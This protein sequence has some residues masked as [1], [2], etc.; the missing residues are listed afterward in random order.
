MKNQ[1]IVKEVKVNKNVIEF[2]YEI[3]GNWKKY[4]DT[5]KK[6]K[7]EYT[8][9]VSQVPKSICVIPL[10]TDIL[11]I[12]WIFDAEIILDE[13]DKNFYESI[14]EFKKGFINMYPNIRLEGKVTVNQLI[15]NSYENSER[16]GQFF[17]GG[18]D[19][20]STL[21][22]H[23][24][25]KPILINIQGSDI[26]VNDQQTIDY[27]RKD[28]C[29]TAEQFRLDI[30][31]IK[32]T[33]KNVIRHRIIN[34]YIKPK[35]GDNYWHGFQHGI[36]I[37]G[38]A[39]PIAYIYQLKMIYIASSFTKEDYATCASDPTIDNFVKL[40][41]TS[42]FHDG[43]NYNRGDKIRN[44][45]QFCNRENEKIKLRVC[46]D[47]NNPNNC[48]NCEKCYRTICE[49]I[50]NG[51]DPH[52]LGFDYKESL[53]KAIKEDF[54]NKIVLSH[55]KNWERIRNTLKEREQ[56]LEKDDSLKWILDYPFQTNYTFIKFVNKIYSAIKKRIKR[57]IEK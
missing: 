19:A 14:S 20:F 44:I 55:T 30:I 31:F 51:Y 6:F 22:T 34:S 42:I 13:I 3:I 10:I 24:E 48:C 50:V 7:I 43:Y 45:I 15:D 25:E 38:H 21:I 46:F 52:K 16:V 5:K 4:F 12:S 18:V 54:Q 47:E 40:S 2:E 8:I 17:S 41:N 35:T 33:F 9:E 53:L 11:P 57:L 23:I 39:A 28:L 36:A 29:H 37:I 27:V 49:I 56:I 26:D 32:S 1:F